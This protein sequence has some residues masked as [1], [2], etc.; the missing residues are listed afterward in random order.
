MPAVVDKYIETKSFLAAH[1]LQTVLLESYRNDFGKYA[2]QAQ[3]KYLQKFFER[4]PYLVGQHFK[5]VK[6]DPDARSR[7]LKV[8]LE[9][10]CW[11]GLIN[12][13]FL[14]RANGIP[15]QSEVNETN[16]N[17]FSSISV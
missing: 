17:L 3:F 5:Y 12:R 8:A 9:Q 2:S 7:E 6:I 11:A 14:T 4:A 16:S 15:L 10:L 1:R 13:V